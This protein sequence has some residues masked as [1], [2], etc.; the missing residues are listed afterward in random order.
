MC[1]LCA[2][3]IKKQFGK[4]QSS[5]GFVW[6]MRSFLIVMNIFPIYT[7]NYVS[8]NC[9]FRIGLFKLKKNSKD[10]CLELNTDNHMNE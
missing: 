1:M 4:K 10:R 9:G 3:L 2:G 8:L 6:G 5:G 7:M